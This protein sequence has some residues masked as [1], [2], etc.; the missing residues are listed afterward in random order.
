MK[1]PSGPGKAGRR[2]LGV[3]AAVL[4]LSGTAR[5]QTQADITYNKDVGG[6]G[7]LVTE[8]FFGAAC[9][10]PLSLS[11]FQDTLIG[12]T[13][14]VTPV[15]DPV[16]EF[17]TFNLRNATGDPITS[18]EFS[19]TPLPIGDPRRNSFGFINALPT[20]GTGTGGGLFT[21]TFSGPLGLYNGDAAFYTG[22]PIF[23][24]VR[25]SSSAYIAPNDIGT[26]HLLAGIPSPSAAPLG[27]NYTINVS[28]QSAPEPG[29]LLQLMLGALTVGS[30]R[31]AFRKRIP[32]I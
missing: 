24:S 8:S 18:V 27:T 19:V 32:R 12:P 28:A 17:Q 16:L 9:R 13:C 4:L 25:F 23:S 15:S 20:D 26:F 14:I 29:T 7:T 31:G 5:A 21:V 22:Q 6:I 30:L 10:I 3:V 2:V 11:F 1:F